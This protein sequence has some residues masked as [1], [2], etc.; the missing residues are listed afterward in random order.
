MIKKWQD[1]FFEDIKMTDTDTKTT[2]KT[3][4][5]ENELK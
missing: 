3:S 4:A 5:D 1:F 2:T